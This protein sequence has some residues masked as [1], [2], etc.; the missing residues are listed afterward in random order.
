[1]KN[2]HPLAQGER[3]PIEPEALHL[4]GGMRFSCHSTGRCC[5]DFWEIPLDRISLARLNS[6]PLSNLSA[7]FIDSE[8]FT[9]PSPGNPGGVALR[10]LEGRCVFLDGSRRCLVHKNFGAKAK[11]QTCIDFPFR[12]IQTPRGVFVGLSMACPSVRANDGPPV[13]SLR[14]ELAENYAFSLNVRSVADPVEL[15][16]GLP[17]GYDAY[18]RIEVALNDLLDIETLSLEE[19]MIAAFAFVQMLE[20]ALRE[21]DEPLEACPQNAL[22]LVKVFREQKYARL[23]SIARKSRGSVRLHRAVIGLLITYRAAFDPEP[24]GRMSRSSYLLYQYFRSMGGLGSIAMP[25]IPGRI[26]LSAL[27]SVRADWEDPYFTYHIL[28]FCRHSLFRKDLII[29]SPLVNGLAY[30][31]LNVALI[32]WYAAGFAVNRGSREIE[33]DDVNEAIG[34]VEKYYCLHT[35]FMRLFDVYPGLSGM[36]ERLIAKTVFAPSIVCPKGP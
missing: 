22:N 36:V 6:L 24:R 21:L 25:P 33:R 13:E 26:R 9:E 23:L 18:E 27:R 29:A 7:K 35:D 8:H 17:I 28:R 1:M 30:M 16:H 20:R 31:L 19:R 4:P 5:Q 3:E 11:P 2:E 34:A 14:A 32:H 10:R 12:Y 15:A